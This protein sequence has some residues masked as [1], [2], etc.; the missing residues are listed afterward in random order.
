MVLKQHSVFHIFSYLCINKVANTIENTISSFFYLKLESQEV[1]IHQIFP[2]EPSTKSVY[3]PEIIHYIVTLWV[4]PLKRKNKNCLSIETFKFPL[5]KLKSQ[6]NEIKI[7][8][9]ISLKICCFYNPINESI[10]SHND[11]NLRISVS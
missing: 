10:R 6:S 7:Y 3:C 5:V 9:F 11:M 8:D 1:C 2:L 4:E